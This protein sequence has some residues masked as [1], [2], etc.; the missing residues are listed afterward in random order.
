[1]SQCFD[2]NTSFPFR[3]QNDSFNENGHMIEA[4]ILYR[5]E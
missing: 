3:L 5:K 2:A 1:M 4:D